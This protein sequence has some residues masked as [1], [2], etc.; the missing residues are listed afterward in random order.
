MELNVQHF[1]LPFCLSIFIAFFISCGAMAEGSPLYLEWGGDKYSL[2]QNTY[3]YQDTTNSKTIEDIRNVEFIRDTRP[4][5][6]FGFFGDDYWIKIKDVV[7]LAEDKEWLL[8]VGYPLLDYVDLYVVNKDGAYFALHS[9]E[10]VSYSDRPYK[11]RNLVYPLSFN[12]NEK[13]DLYLHVRTTGTIRIPLAIVSEEALN[14]TDELFSLFQGGFYGVIIVMALYN[15]LI[16]AITNRNSYLYYV[17]LILSNMLSCGV[18]VGH[19]SEILWQDNPLYAN[20]SLLIFTL[21]F[22][23]FG[24]LFTQS[25][26][27]T[28]YH[29]PTI[30]K[31]LYGI[32]G[33]SIVLLC[34]SFSYEIYTY[35]V[36]SLSGLVLIYAISNIY[37]GL[38]FWH[39]KIRAAKFFTIATSFY[40]IGLILWSLANYGVIPFN[41][42]TTYSPQIGGVLEVLFLAMGLADQINKFKTDAALAKNESKILIRSQ[43]V[44]EKRNRD[45]SFL[46]NSTGQGVLSFNR[47]FIVD[48]E[49]SKESERMLGQ[50]PSGECI[51][52]LLCQDRDSEKQKS[53][54]KESV[55]EALNNDEEF[56]SEMILSLLPTEFEIGDLILKAEYKKVNSDKIMLI[57]T[58]ITDQEKLKEKVHSENEKL[59]MIVLAITD[60][61]DLVD[62]VDKF[63]KLISLEEIS[64]VEFRDLYR[65]IH[66][67]KG[68]FNQFS[69]INLP[70]E[71]HKWES[72]LSN[73][74]VDRED[75]VKHLS[76]KLEADLSII[77]SSLGDIFKG[78]LGFYKA[79]RRVVYKTRRIMASMRKDDEYTSLMASGKLASLIE[80]LD[81]IFLR[82]LQS[83]FNPMIRGC[84]DLASKQYKKIRIET[85]GDPVLIHQEY[86]RDVVDSF[87][88]IFRN[89]VDHGIEQPE[90]RRKLEKSETGS[91]NCHIALKNNEI[92]IAISDDGKGVDMDS[93]KDKVHQIYPHKDIQDLSEYELQQYIFLDNVTTK[94]NVTE[95]SG[96]GV[97]LA[98]TYAQVVKMGGK[99]EFSSRTGEGSCFN[100]TLPYITDT[101]RNMEAL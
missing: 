17:L 27:V 44:I 41:I 14:E 15:I 59:R 31:F 63:K 72:L 98:A 69:F 28:K 47:D 82:S 94:D 49:F 93:L 42:V 95:I 70:L 99:I 78:D 50:N 56:C 23:L 1:P 45:V 19:G 86:Y 96:R 37:I 75:M 7:I 38:V 92:H 89:A 80:S 85:L 46:L 76:E 62:V 26:L 29:S 71:L 79:D 33:L 30:H 81:K 67:F 74:D 40:L 101:Q 48:S 83:M 60:R 97:G 36:R 43:E 53:F 16:F 20:Q 34:L 90:K 18:L 12:R 5:L 24:C 35:V 9:G 25:Y 91:I 6:N 39:K 64:Q 3:Y 73:T 77:T 55:L 57:L 58:D 4:I 88:H 65:E 52:N 84:Y 11:N 100:I 13:H 51:C 66:T 10:F 2:S 54:F 61:S 21:L 32:I 68:L 22:V 8:E 87:I